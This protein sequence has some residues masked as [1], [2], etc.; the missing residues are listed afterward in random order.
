MKTEIKINTVQCRD[1]LLETT[2]SRS[3]ADIEWFPASPL[4]ECRWSLQEFA[5]SYE[6]VFQQ[7]SF[8]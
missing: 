8:L 4:I 5:P 6:P 1:L 2:A 7:K 3:I